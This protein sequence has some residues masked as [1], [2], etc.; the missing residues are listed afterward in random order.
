MV[1]LLPR[2]SEFSSSRLLSQ[3]VKIKAVQNYNFSHGFVAVWNLVSD[4]KQRT[5]IKGIL[6]Q[7]ADR[8]TCA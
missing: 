7:G 1:C 8:N 6:E 5:Q 4:T 2:S 3:N